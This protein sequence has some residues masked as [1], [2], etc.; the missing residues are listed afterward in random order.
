MPRLPGH[1]EEAEESVKARRNTIILTPPTALPCTAGELMTQLGITPPTDQVM[2]AALS[3]QLENLLVAATEDAENYTRR[4]FMLQTRQLQLDTF[5]RRDRRYAAHHHWEHVDHA[6]LMPA[7]PLMAILSFQFTDID[8]NTCTVHYD[9]SLGT[10]PNLPAWTYQRSLGTLTLPGRL[11]PGRYRWWPWAGEGENVVQINFRCGYG[12]PITVTTTANS[13]VIQSPLTFKPDDV[14]RPIS[15]PGAAA[16]PAALNTTIASVDNEGNATLAAPA[17]LAVANATAFYGVKVPE[18][19]RQAILIL[20]QTYY[21][22]GYSDEMPKF[23]S[24]RLKPYYNG[25]S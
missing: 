13:A 22:N 1:E 14:N 2:A 25:N 21:N 4:A 20:A 5:P 24:A 9:P 23:V 19:I 17:V 16:G 10:A 7:P 18:P 6:I 15:I 11:E 12:G 3:A 8:G